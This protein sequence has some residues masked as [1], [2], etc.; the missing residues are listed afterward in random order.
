MPG[1]YGRI[2]IFEAP[3]TGDVYVID[4]ITNNPGAAGGVLTTRKGE[5]L[6][7]IGKELRNEL[8][9]TWIN[10]AMPIDAKIEVHQAD[11]KTV[12]VSIL[13]LVEKKEKYKPRPRRRSNARAAAAITASSWCPTWSSERRPTSRR[14]CP[15]RRPPRPA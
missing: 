11:D 7:L 14:S 13:D 2:G 9:D 4:A 15:A 12:T 8:T 6:G 10:Y 1:C 5:L 3:Y